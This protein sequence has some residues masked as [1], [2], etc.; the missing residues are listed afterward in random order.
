M[1]AIGALLAATGT[2]L[3]GYT[4][5]NSGL[6]SALAQF[7]LDPEF[8]AQ[9]TCEKLAIIEGD[10]KSVLDY[11]MASGVEQF[12]D[13]VRN[14]CRQYLPEVEEAERMAGIVVPT[15]SDRE[16]RVTAQPKTNA[17]TASDAEMSDSE[18]RAMGLDPNFERQPACQRLEKI[19]EDGKSVFDYI[20][21]SGP[22]KIM[23]DIV[24]NCPDSEFVPIVVT[25]ARRAAVPLPSSME[26]IANVDTTLNPDFENRPACDRL[27][28]IAA[29]GKSVRDYM[30]ASGLDDFA[31]AIRTNCGEFLNELEEAEQYFGAAIAIPV[32]D[33]SQLSPCEQLNAVNARGD[34]VAQYIADSDYNTFASAIN[35]T[36]PA[37]SGELTEAQRI[38]EDTRI[39]RNS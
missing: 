27:R 23:D 10:G 22:K 34:S 16:E 28:I 20:I 24:Q 7:P 25:A 4:V 36:C 8:E 15:G 26:G 39:L 33:I 6:T 3:L 38:I 37:Y 35:N 32:S 18:M 11:I 5:K 31:E 9:P 19:E 17:S 29:D 21:A 14:S 30:V 12:S 13:D 2:V 1:P